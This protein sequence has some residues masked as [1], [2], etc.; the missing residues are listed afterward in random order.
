M[1][2]AIVITLPNPGLNLFI[3]NMVDLREPK[4]EDGHLPMCLSYYPKLKVSGV[5]I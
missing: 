4:A 3:A 1:Q 2:T 5:D